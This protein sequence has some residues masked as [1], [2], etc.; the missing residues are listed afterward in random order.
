MTSNRKLMKRKML[1][2][3]SV[4]DLEGKLPEIIKELIDAKA[5]LEQKGYQDLKM[6]HEVE[7]GY[8][9][10]QDTYFYI[11]GRRMETQ[12]E[13]DKR[14]ETGRKASISRKKSKKKKMEEEKKEEFATYLR[15]K[16][17]FERGETCG[18]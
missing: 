6:E 4:Y 7:Y 14:V 13:A 9:D 10:E 15:L 3:F 2:K 8:G 5:T 16:G 12:A 1:R 18:K 17:K 11:S